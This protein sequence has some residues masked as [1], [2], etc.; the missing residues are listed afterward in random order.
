MMVTLFRTGH[1]I[2]ERVCD[3]LET[4]FCM[5]DIAATYGI[6]RGSGEW[7]IEQ[8]RLG[9]RVLLVDKGYFKPG[10]YDGYYRLAWGGT[11][12]RFEY[13]A[14]VDWQRFE[15]LGIKLEPWQRGGKHVL[16]CP[17]TDPVYHFFGLDGWWG[18][19]REHLLATGHQELRI[20]EKGTPVPLEHD[21][22]DCVGVVTF[23]SAVGWEALRRGIPVISDPAH[24]TVGSFLGTTIVDLGKP[25]TGCDRRALF[26]FMANR[27]FTL[28]E[29]EN[30]TARSYLL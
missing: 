6:L 29:I 2:N 1:E 18:P 23:N 10:H 16:I 8:D 4:G 21:L 30:G 9:K 14:A 19:V 5:D 20:R 15:A 28:A 22:T 13:A 7:A 24:S 26:S 27:Q 12:A 25:M 3:A 11:Q 17:P